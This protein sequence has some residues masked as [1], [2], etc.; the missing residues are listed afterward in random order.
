MKLPSFQFYPGD[1]MKDPNLRRCSQA[2]RGVWVDMLCLM[3]ECEQRGVLA[4]GGSPWSRE[5]AAAAVGG[6]TDV[7][8]RCIDELVAKGVCK[9]SEDGALYSKRLRKDEETRVSTRE[10]V[11]KFREK[12][13][14]NDVGNGSVTPQKQPSSSSTSSA[15]TV[16][17]I[18][19]TPTGKDVLQIR[20]EKL[21]NRRESTPWSAAEMRAW[22]AAKPVLDNATPEE[23]NV[24]EWWYSLPASQAPYRKTD[25]AALLNNWHAEIE[26]ARRNKGADALDP[27]F[28]FTSPD[29]KPPVLSS[30]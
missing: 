26:K 29:W 3:F 23:W 28:D 1:W 27:K 14:C 7:T 19:R 24:I 17:H 18:P 25:F 22:K 10:R 21:M 20:A 8:L 11:A 30:P 6:N 13:D 5:D 2:A 9:V 12:Q 4:T 16:K 15:T